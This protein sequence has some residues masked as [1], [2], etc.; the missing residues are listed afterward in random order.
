LSSNSG[1]IG[2]VVNGATYPAL[3]YEY[4]MSQF[5]AD[6]GA[7]EVDPLIRYSF[8]LILTLLMALINFRG[9]DIVGHASTLIYIISMGSFLV[10]TI[11]GI[12]KSELKQGLICG[13]TLDIRLT[14][15]L[16]SELS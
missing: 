14:L 8:V 3:L 12:P 16:H 2:G 4:I 13:C 9:L 7:S 11:I 10:M 6:K 1:W 5:F 15:F